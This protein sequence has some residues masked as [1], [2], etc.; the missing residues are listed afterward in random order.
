MAMMS[1][2][3]YSNYHH[4][5]MNDGI[6]PHHAEQLIRAMG[7]IHMGYGTRYRVAEHTSMRIF[8]YE[9]TGKGSSGWRLVDIQDPRSSKYYGS[10]YGVQVFSDPRGIRV[11]GV[12]FAGGE[13]RMGEKPKEKPKEDPNKKPTIKKQPKSIRHQYLRRVLK[14]RNK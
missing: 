5:F 13:A 10:H 14:E 2:P 9:F 1:S 4:A 3:H 8:E 12:D 6:P 11:G 7:S